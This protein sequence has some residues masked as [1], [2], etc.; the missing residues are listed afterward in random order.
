MTESLELVEIASSPVSTVA[1]ITEETLHGSLSSAQRE[2]IERDSLSGRLRDKEPDLPLLSR[3]P[4]NKVPLANNGYIGHALQRDLHVNSSSVRDPFLPC[5]F[6]G[7]D[8]SNERLLPVTSEE[9]GSSS[10]IMTVRTQSVLITDYEFLKRHWR[11]VP[12]SFL[13]VLVL[14]IIIEY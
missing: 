10:P 9:S 12:V 1:G 7:A 2:E 13:I 4:E 3:Q 8:H 11:T 14:L 6:R 5:L